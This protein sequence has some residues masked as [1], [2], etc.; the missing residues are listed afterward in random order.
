M[1]RL[2]L[3]QCKITGPD[4]FDLLFGNDVYVIGLGID[5]TRQPRTFNLTISKHGKLTVGMMDATLM[6]C[7]RELSEVVYDVMIHEPSLVPIDRTT[8]LE[9]AKA[10]Y[11][12]G[13]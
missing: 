11:E 10:D 1:K 13:L 7:I 8:A 4:T 6:E 9:I 5:P 3:V 12:E 2:E